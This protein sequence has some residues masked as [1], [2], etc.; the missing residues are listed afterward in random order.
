MAAALPACAQAGPD[1]VNQPLTDGCQRN[2]VGLL[3]FTSPEWVWVGGRN[4][5][6]ATSVRDVQGAASLVH[7]ADEDL[8]EG[9]DSY[10]LDF[11]V[12][13]DSQYLGLLAGDQSA[14]GGK[15]NRVHVWGQWA[16]DCGH[17][18]QGIESDQSNP[19]GDLIGTGDYFLPGQVE[20]GAPQDLRGEQTELHPMQAIVDTRANSWQSP[21]AEKETD[22]FISDEGNHA[23]GEERCAHDN[24]PPGG[25]PMQL[26]VFSACVESRANETQ[27]IQGR[28]YTF[29]VPAPPRPSP[30]AQLRYREVEQVK[31]THGWSELRISQQAASSE[32]RTRAGSA[33]WAWSAKRARVRAAS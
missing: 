20:G 10:D 13:P 6:D 26:P 19:Q 17:W 27:P 5:T 31:G 22:A 1:P 30:G 18:G 2:P 15:G 4:T 33:R 23:H 12:A 29:F 28:S 7:T 11:D 24:Q 3:T 9:H 21:A 32:A 8:P 16:W 14:N 25:V